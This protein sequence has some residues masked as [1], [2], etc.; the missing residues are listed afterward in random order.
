MDSHDLGRGRGSFVD[1]AA[2]IRAEVVLVGTPSD[3]LT[4]TWEQAELLAALHVSGL[5]GSLV[6]VNTDTGHD[7]FLIAVDDFGAPLKQLLDR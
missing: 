4:P 1:G 6:V 2:R 3:L 5:E 7:S